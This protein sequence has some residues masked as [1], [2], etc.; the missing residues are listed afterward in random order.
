[1]TAALRALRRA[2]ALLRRERSLWPWAAIPWASRQRF[3][4]RVFDSWRLTRRTRF[5]V[6]GV[7]EPSGVPGAEAYLT[8]EMS[9]RLNAI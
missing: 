4:S 9:V 7:T 2:A 5:G 8:C 1:M 3:C 6:N